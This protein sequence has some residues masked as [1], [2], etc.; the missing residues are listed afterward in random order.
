MG[1]R[2]PVPTPTAVLKLRDSTLVRKR[3]QRGEPQPERGIPTRPHHVTKDARALWSAITKM[4]D[5]MQVLTVIDGGQLERYCFMFVQ[6]RQLQRVIAKFSSTDDLL[7]G[8]LKNDGTR[9]IVRNAWS[10]A[11][12][13]DAALK[14]IEAQFGLTPAARARLSCL[15]SGA[16]DAVDEDDLEAMFFS[17]AG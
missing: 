10:E 1:T 5:D 3:E 2:G 12:R 4:L 11:H 14:Q 8:S 9:P 15:V 17:G 7:V 16:K 6:W 13:L